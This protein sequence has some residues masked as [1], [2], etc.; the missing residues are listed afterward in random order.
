[1]FEAQRKVQYWHVGEI[2]SRANVS[3]CGVRRANGHPRYPA[4]A[5]ANGS[6][7]D[8]R[9]KPSAAFTFD[10]T[11]AGSISL[12]IIPTTRLGPSVFAENFTAS[13]TLIGWVTAG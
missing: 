6:R 5:A 8:L 11:S 3:Q 7:T 13:V 9:D 2:G 12:G 4:P 10:T 1:M